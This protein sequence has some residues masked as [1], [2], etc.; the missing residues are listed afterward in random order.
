MIKID[1]LNKI[2][3]LTESELP[4]PSSC[5]LKE[6]VL[7]SYSSLQCGLNKEHALPIRDETNEYDDPTSSESEVN[8]MS[9]NS[10][11]NKII[12]RS[13][14]DENLNKREPIQESTLQPTTSTEPSSLVLSENKSSHGEKSLTL[15]HALNGESTKTNP[16]SQHSWGKDSTI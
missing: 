1:D 9:L 4:F 8:P 13:A 15:H 6:E 2:K 14:L 5:E 16:P 3:H 7:T 10:I 12:I 11:F